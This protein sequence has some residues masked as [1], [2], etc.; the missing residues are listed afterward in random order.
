M[1]L[2][3][4]CAIVLLALTAAGCGGVVSPS[5]N[6]TENFTNTVSPGGAGPVHTFTAGASGEVTITV[7]SFSPSFSNYFYLIYGQMSGSNCLTIQASAAVV[8]SAA[9]AG[10]IQKGTYCVQIQDYGFFTT[11]ET[12]NIK[13]SHP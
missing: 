12:Y 4:P 2:R 13:V 3:L 1:S 9:V 7:T 10:S 5:N 6:Q 8:N 11:T